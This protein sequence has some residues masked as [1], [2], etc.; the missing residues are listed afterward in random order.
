MEKRVELVINGKPFGKQ[1]P[2]VMKNGITYTPKETTN[3]ETLVKQLYITYNG[4]IFLE[5]AL[6]IKIL[7][8]F[9]IPK[10]TPK[11][12]I[13]LMVNG[14]IRPIKKP[15]MDNIYKIIADSLN[16]IAYH[17]DSQIV[18]AE[19]DKYYSYQPRVEVIITELIEE[20]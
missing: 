16:G 3:Y 12:N 15:D 1:R 14:N 20:V 19:V 5:G 10:S 7:A 11:K 2:R 17:D 9:E 4:G 8:Y 18:Q 13:P 6:K